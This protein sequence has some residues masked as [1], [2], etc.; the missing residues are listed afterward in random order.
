MSTRAIAPI[1]GTTKSSVDRDMQVSRS[2]TP[3]PERRTAT[4]QTGGGFIAPGE[5]IVLDTETTVDLDTGETVSG[6]YIA[7]TG[8]PY[9]PLGDLNWPGCDS[10]AQ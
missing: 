1:V 7:V 9:K 8:R 4:F 10:P 6:R 2:G 3:D 5:K